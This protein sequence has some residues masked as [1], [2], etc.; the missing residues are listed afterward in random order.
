MIRITLIKPPVNKF[1]RCFFTLFIAFCTFL[2][3]KAQN[4]SIQETVDGSEKQ[5]IY[6]QYHDG[7]KMIREST[8]SKLG[9]FTFN[10]P[11][12]ADQRFSIGLDQEYFCS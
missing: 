3:A 11:A 4:L 2:F 8:V 5:K 1:S 10:M 7:A 9:S 6:I 12:S